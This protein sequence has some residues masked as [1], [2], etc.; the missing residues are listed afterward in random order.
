MNTTYI[1]RSNTNNLTL[2]T[3]YDY[4]LTPKKNTVYVVV[5]TFTFYK[6]FET[7]KVFKTEQEALDYVNLVKTV[8][9][10]EEIDNEDYNFLI[11]KHEY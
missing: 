11:T 4:N 6:Y 5:I 2:V 10:V 7:V 9:N 8:N 3:D 1:E